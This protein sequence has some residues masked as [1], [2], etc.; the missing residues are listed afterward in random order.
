MRDRCHDDSPTRRVAWLAPAALQARDKYDLTQRR[1]GVVHPDPGAADALAETLRARGAQVIVLSL[2]ETGLERAEALDPDVVLVKPEHF[3]QDSWSVVAALWQHPWLC[4]TPI[5]FV[6]AERLGS[7]GASA[8]DVRE[9][10]VGIQT[11][12]ADYEL[13]LRRAR[14]KEQFQLRLEQ[15]GPV[16]T[17]RALL[18]SQSSLRVS[19]ETAQRTYALDLGEGLLIGANAVPPRSGRGDELLGVHALQALLAST[20][21]QVSVRSVAQPALTNIMAPLE[22][23]L[24]SERQTPPLIDVPAP[25]ESAPHALVDGVDRSSPMAMAVPALLLRIPPEGD[26]HTAW[27]RA[28]RLGSALARARLKA[29]RR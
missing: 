24:L 26:A 17:L 11:L 10:T 28:A 3:A 12:C 6:P 15:L 14:R 25:R 7:A 27:R 19:I 16:R 9:L 29:S 8:P 1:I 23:L 2:G 13:S 22:V 4:W 5:L 20:G 21:G 18:E